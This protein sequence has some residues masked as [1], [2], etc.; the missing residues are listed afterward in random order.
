M[1]WLLYDNSLRHE[2]VKRGNDIEEEEEYLVF[3]GYSIIKIL[4]D[5]YFETFL[6]SNSPVWEN[7]Q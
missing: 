7:F 4:I 1:D 5:H 6:Q 2:S 3:T